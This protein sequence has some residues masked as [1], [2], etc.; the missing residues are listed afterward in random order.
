MGHEQDSI[1]EVLACERVAKRP[2]AKRDVDPA[3]ATGRSM[4]EL[5]QPAPA[6]GLVGKPR[7]D[8]A[9][10][11]QIEDSELALAQALVEA[12]AA[13][14][15]GLVEHELGGLHSTDVRRRDHGRRRV[16]VLTDPPTECTRLLAPELRQRHVH[17]ALG[18]VERFEALGVRRVSSDIAEALPVSNQPELAGIV[19]HLGAIPTASGDRTDGSP[20]LHIDVLSHLTYEIT[21]PS[22]FHFLIAASET[23][24]QTIVDE[25]LMTMPDVRLS[26]LREQ[27]EGNRL[28]VGGLTP[29]RLDLRYSARVAIEPCEL[30]RNPSSDLDFDA[31]PADVLAYLRPSRY[32]ESDLLTG[33]ATKQFDRALAAW[34]RIDDVCEWVNTHL[35]Y[36]A[37]VTDS[38]TTAIDVLALAAGVC[39]DYAHLAIA[40]CRA[41]GIP[42]RYVSAYAVDLEPPDFHGLFEAYVDGRWYLFDATRMARLDQVVRIGAGRDAADV[43]F[44]SFVGTA[45]LIDKQVS[46]AVVET[47]D[48]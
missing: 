30:A 48:N 37:G 14:D 31:L 32:C 28:H 4:V 6:L 24:R 44:A 8:A 13:I 33:F 25:Q 27:P 5:A 34:G 10:R 26:V 11:E 7:L 18:E 12:Q 3:L 19:S 29:G 45:E 36:V 15:P 2:Q 47:D 39:R 38:S 46:A 16:V 41:L 40:L 9:A 17:V 20:M 42:A 1:V 22:S 43:A 35:D 23:D 21:E